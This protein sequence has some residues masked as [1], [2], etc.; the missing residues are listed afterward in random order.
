MCLTGKLRK[1]ASFVINEDTLYSS[2]NPWFLGVEMQSIENPLYSS[3]TDPP[4]EPCENVEQQAELINSQGVQRQQQKQDLK[5]EQQ[6]QQ[7]QK[8]LQATWQRQKSEVTRQQQ[9]QQLKLDAT[10]QRQQQQQHGLDA[11]RQRQQLQQKKLDAVQQ[12]QQ[13]QQQKL[14]ADRQRQQL[15]QQKLDADR[16]R[17]QQEPDV[18]SQQQ[19]QSEQGL[20]QPIINYLESTHRQASIGHADQELDGQRRRLEPILSE[21]GHDET[22][23]ATPESYRTFEG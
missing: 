1:T 13:L 17:Q 23:D 10:W 11:D 4:V 6:L 15:Q 2:D 3:S 7:Q 5:A 9:Q 14:D 19:Q 12:R 18:A 22:L 8:E 21:A 16:Q 20:V